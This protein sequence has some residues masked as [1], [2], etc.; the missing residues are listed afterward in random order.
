MQIDI[1]TQGFDLSPT[2]RAR[3][4]RRVRSVLSRVAQRVEHVGLHLSDINGPRG[5]IDKRSNV[6]VLLGA[7]GTIVV[8]NVHRDLFRAVDQSLSLASRAV[9]R[10]LQRSLGQRRQGR[11]LRGGP[12]LSAQLG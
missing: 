3:I 11:S 12:R 9:V 4:E 10:R 2:A 7:S 8:D 5:G 1:Q 6:Q